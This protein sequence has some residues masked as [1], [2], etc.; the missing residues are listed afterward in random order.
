MRDL[1]EQLELP[2]SVP[3]H[4]SRRPP[5]PVSLAPTSATTLPVVPPGTSTSPLTARHPAW[6]LNQP[7]PP[8]RPAAHR[9]PSPLQCPAALTRSS[10]GASAPMRVKSGELQRLAAVA[11]FS[12]TRRSRGL[13]P[14]AGERGVGGR[15]DG[16]WAGEHGGGCSSEGVYL[17]AVS[18]DASGPTYL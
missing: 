5:S 14:T 2:P 15:L 12:Q 13:L 10:I 18:E 9:L 1:G 4:H 11:I 7:P 17:G 3:L 8:S 16:L 6:H